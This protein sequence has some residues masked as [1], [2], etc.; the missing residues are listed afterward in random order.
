MLLQYILYIQ[1]HISDRNA[2]PYSNIRQFRFQ[3]KPHVENFNHDPVA[4]Y[5]RQRLLCFLFCFLGCPLCNLVLSALVNDNY[6]CDLAG[7]LINL[8]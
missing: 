1:I 3:S 5:D 2:Y 4:E 8:A 6:S 7:F